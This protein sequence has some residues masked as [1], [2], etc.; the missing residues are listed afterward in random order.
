MKLLELQVTDVRG[1]RHLLLQPAGRN[2]VVWGPNGAGKSAVVDALDFL[3]TGRMSRLVGPGTAGITLGKHGPH[4]DSTAEAATVRGVFSIPELGEVE[5]TRCI[6]HPSV[7]EVAD[8]VRDQLA[9]IL[10][11]AEK[12]QHVLTRREIL[13]FVTGEARSRAEQIAHLM[14]LDEL[15]DLRRTLV[16]T[17]RGSERRTQ[18]ARSVVDGSLARV[19]QYWALVK[20][21]MQR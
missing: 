6:A 2:L 10:A 11:V 21:M 9:P 3:L 1:I 4:I 20:P 15:E 13:R 19:R 12:G 14:N 8:D 17:Q 18:A 16:T 7:L 5:M